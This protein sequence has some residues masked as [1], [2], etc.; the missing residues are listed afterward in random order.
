[1]KLSEFVAQYREEHN[2]SKR[3]FGVMTGISVQQISNKQDA[4]IM[5][6][7]Y[8]DGHN[9]LYP[10]LPFMSFFYRALKCFHNSQE[11]SDRIK[12]M[13]KQIEHGVNPFANK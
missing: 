5:I 9:K 11:D 8:P 2:L 4:S 12:E 1:M 10:T 7:L 13:Q 6:H 3:A